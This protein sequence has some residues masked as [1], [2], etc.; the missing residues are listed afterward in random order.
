MVFASFPWY[1]I[2]EIRPATDL[3]WACLSDKLRARGFEQTPVNLDR[4]VP[5]THQWISG[6]LFFSQACGY[7]VLLPYANSL[8]ILGTPVYRAAGCLGPRYSSLVVVHKDSSWKHLAGL[9]GSR[10]AV[11]TMTSH[12]GMNSLRAMVAPLHRSGRFFSEV[13]V[14]G[15]HELSLK[16]V[17]ERA[18]DVA[19]IDCVTYELLR[20]YRPRSLSQVR[21]LCRTGAMPAPPYV[22]G[23]H[24]SE[25]ERQSIAGALV[26]TLQ[27]PSVRAAKEALLLDR[28]E[29][30]PLAAYEPIAALDRDAFR[31]GYTEI[32]SPY[33]DFDIPAACFRPD[34]A[35]EVP[36]VFCAC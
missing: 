14:T 17:G 33:E 28:I 13:Q 6:R 29:S 24:L 20:R 2:P 4:T 19:A 1:D 21:I 26:E 15:A 25:W 18:A 27:D 9:R 32:G 8:R 7:D 30:L 34:P 23:A 22:A 12:S 36:E 11:N 16:R 10:C 31:R 3:L 35:P 5:Y